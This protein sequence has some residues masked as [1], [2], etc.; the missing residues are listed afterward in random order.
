MI[1]AGKGRE[2]GSEVSQLESQLAELTDDTAAVGSSVRDTW[3]MAREAADGASD[4]RDGVRNAG[5][6]QVLHAG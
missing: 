5:T 1:L 3:R 6:I 2:V 4:E